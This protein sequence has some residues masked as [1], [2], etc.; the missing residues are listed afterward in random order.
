M[1]IAMQVLKFA[2]DL[3]INDLHVEEVGCLGELH[4]SRLYYPDTNTET[5][6]KP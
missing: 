6:C 3:A 5:L 2:Q 1:A 4:S